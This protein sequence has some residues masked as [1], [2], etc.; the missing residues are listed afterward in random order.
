MENIKK[1]LLLGKE[2]FIGKNLLEYLAGIPE[3]IVF[4]PNKLE[5]DV[6][7]EKAVKKKLESEFYDV[8]INSAVYNPRVGFNKDSSKEIEYNLR[9]F[10]NFEK[11]QDLYGKMLYFG[12]GAEFDKSAE[13]SIVNEC[14]VPK[15][16]PLNDYGLYKYVINKQILNSKNIVNLRIFGLF[17]KYENWAKTF[18]SGACCKAIKN[19][20]I[21]I[22]QDVLFDYLYIE[23]FMIIIKWFIDNTCKFKD[24]NIVSGNAVYLSEI[25]EKVIKISEKELQIVICRDNIG[26]EYTASNKRLLDEIGKIHFT[27]IDVA[28]KD[29]YKWYEEKAE[30]LEIYDLI[31]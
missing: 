7:D 31:Y 8:I 4:A 25:A 11:Y 21:T 18:I 10:Y 12:S 14:Y 1:I 23:D 29:L 30:E 5:L 22:R 19:L 3:Y 6:T 2:G 16:I 24:Y 15:R 17:G 28:I 9:I 20:P 13:I 27:P 26:N